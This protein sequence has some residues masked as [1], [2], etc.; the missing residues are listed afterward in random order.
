MEPLKI[1]PILGSKPVLLRVVLAVR[2]LLVVL[3]ELVDAL[4]DV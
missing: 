1:T 2:G 4:L 3:K